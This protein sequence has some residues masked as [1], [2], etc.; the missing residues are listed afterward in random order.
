MAGA[1]TVDGSLRFWPS[2]PLDAGRDYEFVSTLR[3]SRAPA[4]STLGNFRHDLDSGYRSIAVDRVSPSIQAAISFQRILAHVRPLFRSR[5]ASRAA[6]STSRSSTTRGRDVPDVV[7]PLDTDLWN[8][9]RTRYTV[10]LDPGRVKREIL[11]NRADGA[12]HSTADRSHARRPGLAGRTRSAA[13]QRSSAGGFSSDRPRSTRSAPRSGRS[14]PPAV[15]SRDPVTVTF[16]KPLDFGLLQRSLSVRR[17]A[18]E[19]RR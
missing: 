17:G 8:A 9:E 10:I 4:S 14:L 6:G 2:F 3:E 19:Y 12:R 7:V 5:W 15:G 18:L 13:D 1:Y 11:P 16:P